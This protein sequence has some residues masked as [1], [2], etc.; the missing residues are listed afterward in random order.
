[1]IFMDR[2]YFFSASM[3][4]ELNEALEGYGV[5]DVVAVGL[6]NE[7]EPQ[8]VRLEVRV[9]NAEELIPG[10]FTTRLDCQ[11]VLANLGAVGVDEARRLMGA[12]SMACWRVMRENWRMRALRHP[13]GE[14]ADAEYD[15]A[16]FLVL[17]LVPEVQPPEVNG[18]SYEGVAAFRA[19]VQ[20]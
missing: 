13:L 6:V 3:A 20:F 11:L 19:W 14:G 9:E 15:A 5:T 8:R 4:L 2:I 12:V 1:M 10:N 17:E 7:P 18:A 16:P